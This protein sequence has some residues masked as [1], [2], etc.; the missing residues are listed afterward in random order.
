MTPGP[1]EEQR[2]EQKEL[3]QKELEPKWIFPKKSQK[4]FHQ[5]TSE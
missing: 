5:K 3:E 1:R 4:A 2:T